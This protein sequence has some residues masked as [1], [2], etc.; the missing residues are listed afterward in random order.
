VRAQFDRVVLWCDFGG[1]RG[2]VI[3][4]IETSPETREGV[5]EEIGARTTLVGSPDPG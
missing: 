4:G 5:R 1:E 3:E 2:W